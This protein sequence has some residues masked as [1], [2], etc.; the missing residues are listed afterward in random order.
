M[1]KAAIDVGSNSVLLLVEARE[2]IGWRV[3][4]EQS[5][6]TALGSGVKQTGRIQDE[7]MEATLRALREA[8]AMAREAGAVEVVAAATMAARIAENTPSFLERAERQG[9]PVFV[10]SGEDE[11][12]LGFR[13]V[14]N[15]PAFAAHPRISIIDPG[16]NS[17]ELVTAEREASGWRT[18]FRKSFPVGTLGLRDGPLAEERPT[19]QQRLRAAA[20]IDRVIGMDYRPHEA[21]HAVVLGAT[22]TNLI[23]IRDRITEWDPARVHGQI[24]DFEEVSRAVGWLCD[25][26]DAERAAIPGLERGREKTI[27]IGALVLERF[28]HAIHVLGCS[29]SVRGWRHALLE[30]GL[31]AKR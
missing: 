29:V 21:G 16:G 14:A 26:T 5:W 13:A 20:E 31:P 27:H 3:V 17:T 8:Y 12:E 2:D 15:D 11:A 30:E 9:T 28:L 6:V 18:L 24:L 10:L 7:P 1:I 23:T 19:P 22:G 25:M 4:T